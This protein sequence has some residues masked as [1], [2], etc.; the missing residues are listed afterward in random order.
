MILPSPEPHLMGKALAFS[1]GSEFGGPCH[2]CAQVH[3]IF[4]LR[5]SFIQGFLSPA[6]YCSTLQWMEMTN[7]VSNAISSNCVVKKQEFKVPDLLP[8]KHKYC[9]YVYEL[10]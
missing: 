3:N 5:T 4:S 8:L 10:D 6:N 7:A 1:H 2:H 9:R